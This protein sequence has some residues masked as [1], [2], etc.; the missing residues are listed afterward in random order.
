MTPLTA[1][2]FSGCGRWET[3]SEGV[4]VERWMLLRAAGA[5]QMVGMFY[6]FMAVGSPWIRRIIEIS[7][8]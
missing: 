7:L 6:A 1:L 4:P 2:P 5:L 3:G 8:P